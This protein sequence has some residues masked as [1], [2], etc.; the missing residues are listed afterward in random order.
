MSA[1]SI[2]Y[3]VYYRYYE[4][5]KSKI[6]ATLFGFKQCNSQIEIWIQGGDSLPTGAKLEKLIFDYLMKTVL[7]NRG[8]IKIFKVDYIIPMVSI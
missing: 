3:L 7:I 8:D 1:E 2:S 5:R 4:R 6:L